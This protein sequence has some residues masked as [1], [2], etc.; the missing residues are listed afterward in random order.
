MPRRKGRKSECFSLS[1]ARGQSCFLVGF[2][3]QTFLSPSFA[4]PSLK[5]AQFLEDFLGRHGSK[6]IDIRAVGGP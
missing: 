1:R 3:R 5:I 4:V 2:Y 6:L